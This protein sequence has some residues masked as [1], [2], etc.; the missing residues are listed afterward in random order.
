MDEYANMVDTVS[1]ALAAFSRSA[2]AHLWPVLAAVGGVLVIFAL[3][4][5]VGQS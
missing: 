3:L 5:K 2:G 4:R 1:A